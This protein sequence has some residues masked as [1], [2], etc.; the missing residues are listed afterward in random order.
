VKTCKPIATPLHACIHYTKDMMPTTYEEQIT[1][2]SMSYGN[3]IGYLMYFITHTRFDIAFI[4][5]HLTQI[6]SNF[7]LVH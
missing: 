4:V 1:M 5:N 2:P 3:A 6:M 7:G